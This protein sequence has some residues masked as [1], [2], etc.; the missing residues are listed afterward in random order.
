MGK[1]SPYGR[2]VP[3]TP[4]VLSYNHWDPRKALPGWD[5]PPGGWN[6]WPCWLHHMWS[7]KLSGRREHSSMGCGD[8]LGMRWR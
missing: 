7:T 4:R 5:I 8:G 6:I 2:K 1:P 3:K